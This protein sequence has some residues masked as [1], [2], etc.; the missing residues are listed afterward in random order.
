[1]TKF[2]FYLQFRKEVTIKIEKTMPILS[3]GFQFN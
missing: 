3:L 1:M 2:V